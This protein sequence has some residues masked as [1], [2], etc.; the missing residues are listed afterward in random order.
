MDSQLGFVIR[1]SLRKKVILSLSI[2]TTPTIL[3]KKINIDRGSVS[4]TLIQLQEKGLSHLWQSK[5]QNWKN[6]QINRH[7]KKQKF[8]KKM[9]FS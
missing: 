8:S 1:G 9:I 5:R 6:L 4:R 3:S 7:H 2:P